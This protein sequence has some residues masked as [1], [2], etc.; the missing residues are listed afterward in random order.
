[1]ADINR[2]HRT[3]WVPFALMALAACAPANDPAQTVER[4]AGT[5]STPAHPVGEAMQMQP[6]QPAEGEALPDAVDVQRNADGSVDV[7]K[8]T[9]ESVALRRTD[10]GGVEI[11]RVDAAAEQGADSAPAKAGSQP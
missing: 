5:D 10:D 1:M 8:A 11:R 7:R 3:L 2:L 9:P 6:A 4:D